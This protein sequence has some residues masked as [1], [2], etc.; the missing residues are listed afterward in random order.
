MAEVL[1]IE[2]H[3]ASGNEISYVKPAG[4]NLKIVV[5]LLMFL[6]AYYY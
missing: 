3:H 6:F 2:K 1:L 5:Y 4:L